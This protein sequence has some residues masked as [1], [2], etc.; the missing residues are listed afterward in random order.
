VLY[1][2]LPMIYKYLTISILFVLCVVCFLGDAPRSALTVLAPV[3]LDSLA[4]DQGQLFLI[5]APKEKT[6]DLLVSTQWAAEK[7]IDI[8]SKTNK[9]N[10]A[11][12]VFKLFPAKSTLELVST[13]FL[14]YNGF[15]KADSISFSYVDTVTVRSFWQLPR[16]AE[17]IQQVQNIN[18]SHILFQ[19]RGW[20]DTI[21]TSTHP[22]PTDTEH[23]LFRI[24]IQFIPGV[25]RIY[26]ATNF[27]KSDAVEFYAH[28]VTKARTAKSDEWRFHGSQLA[29]S[30][31]K[32]HKELPGE[33]NA[34][35][36]RDKCGVCHNEIAGGLMKHGPAA[37]PKE[38]STCHERS[39][40]KN[41]ETV[42][43]GVPGVCFDCHTEKKD[44]VETSAV[45]HKVAGD[46]VICHS[47]HATDQPKFLKND[48]YK[49]CTGCHQNY[50]MNHPVDKHP[51]R[52]SKLNK[53]S[54]EEI[55]C[56]SCH[57]PHGSENQSLLK[58]SGGS[59]AV[60]M[61]CHQK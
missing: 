13:S 10:F 59:M 22:N 31:A 47:P 51:L 20:K 58:A 18:A 14:F 54:T 4:Y 6:T 25:N 56:I 42:P 24:P 35:G 2:I 26:F 33:T 43:K 3:C 21:Y 5:M 27:L 50:L 46:C 1:R 9:D 17:I 37:E 19:I 34:A 38:C 39:V 55:S 7:L 44:E 40:E 60:C 61:Q 8:S 48:I 52:F 30:C 45:K 11:K 15:S 41:I 53:E 32:C 29:I 57:K 28:Y 36:E 12:E 23:K 49:L 16:F